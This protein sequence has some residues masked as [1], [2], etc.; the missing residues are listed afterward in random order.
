MRAG[1]RA[2][3]RKRRRILMLKPCAQKIKQVPSSARAE[4][5]G[6]QQ[7]QPSCTQDCGAHVCPKGG[8]TRIMR[9]GSAVDIRGAVRAR[10]T[11]DSSFIEKPRN[12]RLRRARSPNRIGR[13]T[14]LHMLVRRV[15]L[16][17]LSIH[18]RLLRRS[19]SAGRRPNVER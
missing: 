14:P 1:A 7:F 18:T 5:H 15:F 13:T 16:E 8:A 17:P 6:R 12:F 3:I 10:A 19:F 2:V 11:P 4:A 9:N